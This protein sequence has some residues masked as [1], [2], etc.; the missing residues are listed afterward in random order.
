MDLITGPDVRSQDTSLFLAR[1]LSN[2]DARPLAWELLQA[3]WDDLQKK[4]GQVFGSPLLI[5]SLGQFCDA[6]RR[7]EVEQFFGTHKV[8]EA[9]R[10]LQQALER[11][12]TCTELAEAQS[13]K[14]ETWL[15]NR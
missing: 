6:K 8:A 13:S 14:L 7:S 15:Q 11:I 5:G 10:T 9:E 2:P 12:S 3:R 1:L 4:A